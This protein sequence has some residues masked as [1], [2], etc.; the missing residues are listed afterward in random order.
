MIGPAD[1]PSRCLTPGYPFLETSV[2]VP[3]F[4]TE[5]RLSRTHF[6]KFRPKTSFLLVSCQSEPFLHPESISKNF[7]LSSV[8]KFL[9][10]ELLPVTWRTIS[11]PHIVILLII[12]ENGTII[13]KM[14]Q[15]W[16]K[17][18][19]IKSYSVHLILHDE[20]AIQ[21]YTMRTGF[22]PISSL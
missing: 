12:F 4:S 2:Y 18:A 16:W 17:Q 20:E 3:F 8:K 10:K 7:Q 1:L 13:F 9:T 21:R 22:G 19:L 15:K 6:G 14:E 5:N 11:M